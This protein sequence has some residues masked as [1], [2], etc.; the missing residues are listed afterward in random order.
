VKP[1]ILAVA[2]DDLMLDGGVRTIT[3]SDES[4]RFKASTSPS[5]MTEAVGLSNSSGF[6]PCGKGVVDKGKTSV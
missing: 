2:L 3:P 1:P 6:A 5:G 4:S